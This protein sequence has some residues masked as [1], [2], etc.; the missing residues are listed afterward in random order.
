MQIDEYYSNDQTEAAKDV[1]IQAHCYSRTDKHTALSLITA[2]RN[3]D[4]QRWPDLI[5]EIGRILDYDLILAHQ[6]EGFEHEAKV[7]KAAQL[8][9]IQPF[10]YVNEAQACVNHDRPV[11]KSKHYE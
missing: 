7:L 9:N 2:L 5:N 1:L 8:V 10:R 3:Y 6:A 4:P 11:N